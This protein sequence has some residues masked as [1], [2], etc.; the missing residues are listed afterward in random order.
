MKRTLEK[1]L[2]LEVNIREITYNDTP[3]FLLLAI[4][5][6]L[7]L[8]LVVHAALGLAAPMLSVKY[9]GNPV[10]FPQF[11]QNW[12]ASIANVEE[13]L[14][15]ALESVLVQTKRSTNLRN[16][17]F[18]LAYGV[19]PENLLTTDAKKADR[20]GLDPHLVKGE[21]KETLGILG[22]P[23]PLTRQL[24]NTPTVFFGCDNI[25][26][27]TMDILAHTGVSRFLII[28]KPNTQVAARDLHAMYTVEDLGETPAEILAKKIF[29]IHPEA[30]VEIILEDNLSSVVDQIK[31]VEII[32]VSSRDAQLRECAAKVFF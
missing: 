19:S 5:E 1:M 4:G 31:T 7:Q 13:R 17:K 8:G 28:D 29:Y 10:Y 16:R 21:I 30:T 25:G 23:L 14:V 12:N 20:A 18:S 24:L 9:Q 11:S 26:A 6:E 15:T 3:A 27:C 22:Q 2:G 32:V